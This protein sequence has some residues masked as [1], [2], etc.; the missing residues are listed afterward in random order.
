GA[1]DPSR[2][3]ALASQPRPRRPARIPRA[4]G[5]ACSG[6]LPV[7]SEIEVL[8]LAF[9]TVPEPDPAAV[10]QAR[11]AFLEHV[12]QR[13]RRSRQ[14]RLVAVLAAAVAAT[15]VLALV[16]A[17]GRAKGLSDAEIM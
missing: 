2:D 11:A 8:E 7:M 14:L 5:N 1:R 15:A 6:G 12:G 3:G 9:H 13:R 16:F 4:D 10:G 17:P